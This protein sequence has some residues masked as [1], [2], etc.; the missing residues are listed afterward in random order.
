MIFETDFG[1]SYDVV[2]FDVMSLS[3]VSFRASVQ[4]VF[5]VWLVTVSLL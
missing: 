1:K 5:M 4:F 3:F 2:E